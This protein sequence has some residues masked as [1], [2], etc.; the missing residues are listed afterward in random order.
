MK[1]CLGSQ[2]DMCLQT[3]G[4]I[5]WTNGTDEMVHDT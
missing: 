3:Q 4:I 2:R 1:S 5:G